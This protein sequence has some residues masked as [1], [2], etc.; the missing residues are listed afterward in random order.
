M[1]ENTLLVIAYYFPPMGLSG[2]Q[3][4]VKFIKYLPEFGWNVKVLT[5]GDESYYAFDDTLMNEIDRGEIEVF[6]TPSKSKKKRNSISFP[7]YTKQ[8]AGRWLQSI[9][10]QP[11]SKIKWK[12]DALKIGEM[13]LNKYNVN[14]ILATAPPFTDFLVAR[15][16]SRRSGKPY[17]IDYRDSWVDNPFHYYPTPFHK[18]KSIEMEK[19]VLIHSEK[20]FVTTRHAKE[21]I[22]KRYRLL[23][24]DDIM[25]LPHG[26]DP[27]DFEAATEV[28]NKDPEKFVITHSGMFQD[29][30]TPKYFL[31]G[32]ASFL[33]NN[34][35]ARKNLEARF[36]GLMRKGHLKMIQKFALEKNVLTTGNVPH[37]EAVRHLL[38]S[39]VLW[40]MLMDTVR[41]PGKLYEYFGAEKTIL[42]CVP[43]GIIKTTA[44][45]S[46]AAIVTG[47]KD[48]K[49]IAKALS[50]LY[51]LWKDGKLPKP[52]REFT[53][54]YNRK[55]LTRILSREIGFAAEIA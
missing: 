43:D 45:E 18:S 9:F 10:Y 17:L 24:H 19:D 42:A 55:S 38:E 52:S 51:K 50:K 25:I 7:P 53:E 11:D 47:P 34:P 41:S 13:I 44:M 16:L 31:R 40:F 15:E 6:R 3:R 20:A 35:A 1:Q 4:I 5:A 46:G 22:L 32:L 39:D 36:V 21:L 33:E 23:S 54:Q 2:V 27:E 26:F 28:A 29:N 30:R 49:A 14:A 37:I 48:E 12:N 8:K